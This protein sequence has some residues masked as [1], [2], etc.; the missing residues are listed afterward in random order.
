MRV[1]APAAGGAWALHSPLSGIW[2]AI[3]PVTRIDT[4][5]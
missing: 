4:V 2:L 3:R 1:E 5:T